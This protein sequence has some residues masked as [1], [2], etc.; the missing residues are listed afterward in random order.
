[1]VRE[2]QRLK[3]TGEQVSTLLF[4]PTKKQQLY[5]VHIIF[6]A[7]YVCGLLPP[8]SLSLFSNRRKVPF[9]RRLS[10]SLWLKA[11]DLSC[12]LKSLFLGRSMVL[13]VSMQ[14]AAGLISLLPACNS[15][16]S[17]SPIT[18]I[19]IFCFIALLTLTKFF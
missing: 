19:C 6:S 8:F 5:R 13:F 10:S 4:L 9:S 15:P 16:T 18:F 3:S 14:E 12:Q 2:E 17:M 1:M 7:V 11:N